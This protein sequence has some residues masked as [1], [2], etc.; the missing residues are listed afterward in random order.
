MSAGFGPVHKLR[1]ANSVIKV[2]SVIKNSLATYLL[3]KITNKNHAFKHQIK[4]MIKLKNHF[5]LFLIRF[6]LHKLQLT[7]SKHLIIHSHVLFP[8]NCK[9]QTIIHSAVNHF[10]YLVNS[11][12]LIW[13]RLE[14]TSDF[15]FLLSLSYVSNLISIKNSL[16]EA[17]WPV[18]ELSLATAVNFHSEFMACNWARET[19]RFVIPLIN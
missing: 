14:T 7:K 6:N 17:P 10:R 3:K 18:A 15:I 9:T 8:Q 4:A 13:S 19:H 12:L 2:Q 1:N 5:N 11:V 16:L